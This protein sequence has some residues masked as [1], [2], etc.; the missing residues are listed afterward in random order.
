MSKFSC[1]CGHTIVDQATNLSFRAELIPDQSYIEFV[2]K[3]EADLLALFR[4]KDDKER[5]E[6]IEKMFYGPPY[7]ADAT[8]SE[9]ISD[10]ISKH[11]ADFNKTV[12]QCE[13]CGRIWI[14]KGKRN[15]FIA[16]LPDTDDWKG[17]LTLDD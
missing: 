2:S 13:R 16:F 1:T 17:I 10:V 9:L 11:Y 12:Y 7:P 5:Q 6:W 14:Q 15:R 8:D 3:V 4:V